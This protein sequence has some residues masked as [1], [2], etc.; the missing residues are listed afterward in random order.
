MGP[1]TSVTM[2]E[3]KE[4]LSYTQPSTQGSVSTSLVLGKV[5]FRWRSCHCRW[6]KR[7]HLSGLRFESS[8]MEILRRASWLKIPVLLAEAMSLSRWRTQQRWSGTMAVKFS[9]KTWGYTMRLTMLW[10][11]S[12][13]IWNLPWPPTWSRR[14]WKPIVVEQVIPNESKRTLFWKVQRQKVLHSVRHTKH[15]LSLVPL[16]PQWVLRLTS[17]AGPQKMFLQAVWGEQL[18]SL[19][20]QSGILWRP[21]PAADSWYCLKVYFVKILFVSSAVKWHWTSIPTS[22]NKIK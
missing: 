14:S 8:G 3:G 15:M 2:V 17:T 16:F 7:W 12:W 22:V 18:F 4:L 6:R 5:P 10:K 11:T 9:N 20:P 13:R 19:K 1:L 21:L